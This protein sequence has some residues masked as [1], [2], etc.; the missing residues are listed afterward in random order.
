MVSDNMKSMKPITDFSQRACRERF[1]SLENG[2][3]KTPPELLEPKTEDVMKRIQSRRDKE[4]KF[5]A[6]LSIYKNVTT[7]VSKTGLGEG[8]DEDSMMRGHSLDN[9]AAT[10]APTAAVAAAIRR[11]I[12]RRLAAARALQSLTDGS[13]DMDVDYDMDADFDTSP[14]PHLSV[15]AHQHSNSTTTSTSSS[16]SDPPSSG[17]GDADDEGTDG[18]E[19]VNYVDS[20]AY[21]NEVESEESSEHSEFE[22]EE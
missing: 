4:K 8:H 22:P 13:H 14:P 20:D 1:E 17:D 18:L 19:E 12:P 10:S 3:A 6:M 2:T 16:L 11:R 21:A 5:Q 9:K 7:G 15:L